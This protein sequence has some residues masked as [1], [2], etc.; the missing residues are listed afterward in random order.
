MTIRGIVID[1]EARPLQGV[2][3]RSAGRAWFRDRRWSNVV[4]SGFSEPRC[5]TDEEGQFELPV[6]IPLDEDTRFDLWFDKPESFAPTF[7]Y[8]V[9][10]NFLELMVVMKRGVLVTGCVTS[11]GLFSGELRPVSRLAVD[12]KLPSTGS[13]YRQRVFT[14]PKG[15]YTLR[16]SPPPSG[17]RWQLSVLGQGMALDVTEKDGDP[18]S[19]P[20]FV[21]TVE[22]RGKETTAQPGAP[23]D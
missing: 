14:D 21:I 19:G 8:G 12:L 22:V 2:T 18:I 20:D 17:R 10:A 23:A 7:L 6:R 16:A 3:V 5:S 9:S 1:E 15:R 11:R 4:S 13:W